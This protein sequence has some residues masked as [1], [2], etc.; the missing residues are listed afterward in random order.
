MA[1][2]VD[3]RSGT[4]T[5]PAGPWETLAEPREFHPDT[6]RSIVGRTLPDWDRCVRM[7]VRA[8][9]RLVSCPAGV[10][11]VAVTP[12]GPVLLEGNVPFG[13]EVAQFA[14]GVPLL[15]T[16]LCDAVLAFAAAHG[17][18]AAKRSSAIIGR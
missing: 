5:G 18:V 4:L 6:G 2:P 12:N 7:C 14:T 3:V 11:D 13:V 8:H 9:D 15:S 17:M 1:C 16:P 10:W